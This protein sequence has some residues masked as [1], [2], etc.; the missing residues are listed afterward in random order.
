MQ[1]NSNDKAA[2]DQAALLSYVDDLIRDRKDPHVNDQNK[3]LVREELL[4]Q[5]N[6][7]I[8][9]HLLN[10][11]SKKDQIAL[12]EFLDKN[13][14]DDELNK[15]FMDKIPNLDVEIAAVLLNFRT[16]YLLPVTPSADS[17]GSLQ[18]SSGQVQS[19]QKVEEPVSINPVD[20]APPPPPPPAPVPPSPEEKFN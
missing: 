6:E 12:D 5:I 20:M 7:D 11:L 16:A 19:A 15:F 9:L 1:N 2:M 17:T 10:L 14:T 3:N 4:K 8:N 13:P 18:A